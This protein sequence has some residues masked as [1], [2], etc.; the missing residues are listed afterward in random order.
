MFSLETVGRN[1]NCIDTQEYEISV[2]D[3]ED[4][5]VAMQVI[6]IKNISSS[7]SSINTQEIENLF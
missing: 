2:I 1:A 4:K 6:G 3:R 7:I 5:F